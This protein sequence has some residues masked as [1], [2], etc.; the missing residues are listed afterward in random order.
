MTAA[1]TPG[2]AISY[3]DFLDWSATANACLPSPHRQ[4]G[5][6]FAP[7]ELSSQH[8]SM[9]LEG[10]TVV[11]TS[12]PELILQRFGSAPTVTFSVSAEEIA[13]T[14][15][16]TLLVRNPNSFDLVVDV[17][18]SLGRGFVTGCEFPAAVPAQGTAMVNLFWAPQKGAKSARAQL[19]LR[20]TGTGSNAVKMPFTVN[21]EGHRAAHQSSVRSLGVH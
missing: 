15:A 21:L 20:A 11:A 13:P 7:I 5:F 16:R 10:A 14:C 19:Q 18:G 17:S 1:S 4:T 2:R 6:R 8:V 12:T 3:T 9:A